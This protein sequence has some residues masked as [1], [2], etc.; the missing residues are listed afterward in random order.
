MLAGGDD[1]KQDG[2][3]C[4]VTSSIQSLEDQKEIK[5]LDGAEAAEEIL[6]EDAQKLDEPQIDDKIDDDKAIKKI[7]TCAKEMKTI[8]IMI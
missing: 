8:P 4:A 6:A 7:R 5:S 3:S 1:E 2:H